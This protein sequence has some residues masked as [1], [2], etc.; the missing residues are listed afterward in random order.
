MHL[1]FLGAF[2]IIEM[3]IEQD[4]ICVL[5][6]VSSSSPGVG[7]ADQRGWFRLHAGEVLIDQMVKHVVKVGVYFRRT[8][9]A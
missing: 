1:D 8:G 5:G 2:A 7:P 6:H 3:A 4:L 9:M